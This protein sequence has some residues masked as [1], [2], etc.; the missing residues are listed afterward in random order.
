MVFERPECVRRLAGIADDTSVFGD[1]RDAARHQLAKAIGL[2]VEPCTLERGDLR[3]EISNQLRFV[4]ETTLERGA[5]L[6]TN[7]PREHGSERQQRDRGGDDGTDED[8][9][10]KAGA[11]LGSDRDSCTQNLA[12]TNQDLTASSASL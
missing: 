12:R 1:Q 9:R 8:L 5:L 7:L 10:A 2:D 3:E 11:H 6:R 4:R